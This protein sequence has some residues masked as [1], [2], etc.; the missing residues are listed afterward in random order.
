MK[1]VF[2]VLAAVVAAVVGV[3][4]TLAFIDPSRRRTVKGGGGPSEL[5]KLDDLPIGRPEKRDVVSER[6]DAWD[7]S[8]PKP[9]GAVWLVRR[10]AQR[11]DAYSIVCPHLGCP[12]AFDSAKRVFA[13]PCHESAFAVEDGHRLKGPAP[14]GLDP[15]PVE[16]REGK[17]FV[18]YKQFIQGIVSRREA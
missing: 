13:C 9:V 6:V 11:V 16:I 2:A 8:D 7:R 14:R 15:L 17:V 1:T 3:P 18:T 12:I 10:D 4:L 5:G